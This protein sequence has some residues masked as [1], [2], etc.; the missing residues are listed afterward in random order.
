MPNNKVEFAL[1]IELCDIADEDP[2]DIIDDEL[3][4]IAK[5]VS[6]GFTSGEIITENGSGW[7]SLERSGA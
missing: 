1:K 2:S 6:E 3:P 5:M 7:W 4:R